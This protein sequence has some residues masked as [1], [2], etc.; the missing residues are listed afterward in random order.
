MEK[1]D[2]LVIDGRLGAPQAVFDELSQKDND[3]LFN[4]AKAYKDKLFYS[5]YTPD[6]LQNV[7]DIMERFPKII[8]ENSEKEQADP[9]VIA[10]AI[11]YKDQ[12]QQKLLYQNVMHCYRR[13][14]QK[15]KR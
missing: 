8:D 5:K 11:E 1:L 6:F 13:E 9:Y 3:H 4:W 10:M 7:A 15:T 14:Y 12:P 2:Q